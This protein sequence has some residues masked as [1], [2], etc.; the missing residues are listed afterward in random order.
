MPSKEKGTLKAF[1]LGELV[2]A[3]APAG[4]TPD[5]LGLDTLCSNAAQT[6]YPFLGRPLALDS[7]SARTV[8]TR[9]ASSS[10]S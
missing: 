10:C 5:N 8:P 4:A 6:A 3:P 2:V 9:V 1:Q 7:H